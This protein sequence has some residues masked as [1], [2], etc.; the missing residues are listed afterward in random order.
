MIFSYREAAIDSPLDL[1]SAS[2]P[3]NVSSYL[4][5]SIPA[6]CETQEGLSEFGV[7]RGEDF[8]RD[9]VVKIL[10]GQ[11]SHRRS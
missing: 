8:C 4:R 3:E 5:G 9:E 2:L 1:S 6:C 11:R 7:D 10:R